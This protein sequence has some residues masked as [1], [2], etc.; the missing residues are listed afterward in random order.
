[1]FLVSK[2]LGTLSLPSNLVMVLLLAGTGLS[3]TR[4]APLARR[5]LLAA[6]LLVLVVAETPL[7][8][9]LAGFLEDRFSSHEPAHVDGVI[10]LGGAVDPRISRARGYPSLNGA[11]DRVTAMAALIHRHPEARVVY[12]GGSGDP[13]YPDETEAPI[14]RQ[15]LES[16]GVDTRAVVFEDRSRNTHENA[17]FSR[18]VMAPRPGETWLLVTSA[19]H[20]PRA[21][22]S[23]R[24]V[25]WP[26]LPFPVNYGTTGEPFAGFRPTLDLGGGLNGLSSILHEYLGLAWYRLQGW[27]PAFFP[28]PDEG[29]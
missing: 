15:L 14:A 8:P 6:S 29:L 16:I 7:S 26:V 28:G 23:F 25:G 18:Q 19:V 2:I 24:A 4:F 11:A 9:D 3:F 13:L 22:G 17:V 12:S 27:T 21:V 5:I 1:M 20:M 10:V